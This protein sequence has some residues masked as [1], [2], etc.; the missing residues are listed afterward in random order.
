MSKCLLCGGLVTYDSGWTQECNGPG[1][2]NFR[3]TITTVAGIFVP[4]KND[5]VRW[6]ESVHGEFN[7]RNANTS[8]VWCEIIAEAWKEVVVGGFTRWLDFGYGNFI[9]SMNT[10]ERPHPWR[11]NTLMHIDREESETSTGFNKR[12]GTIWAKRAFWGPP[13]AAGKLSG[14]VG[15]YFDGEIEW[16]HDR[17]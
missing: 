15:I 3:N 1:C 8:S 9:R 12:F 17:I 10:A 14:C 5:I 2:H 13:S 6:D 4:A 7:R 16:P 11:T